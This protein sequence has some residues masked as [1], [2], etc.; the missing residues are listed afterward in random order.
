M[1]LVVFWRRPPFALCRSMNQFLHYVVLLQSPSSP[2]LIIRKEEKN[3]RCGPFEGPFFADTLLA[4]LYT[5]VKRLDRL[6]CE[7][8][9]QLV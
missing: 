3:G 4:L 1:V 7:A 6:V 5:P 9:A 2:S 8:A